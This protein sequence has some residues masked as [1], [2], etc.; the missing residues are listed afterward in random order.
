MVKIDG[1]QKPTAMTA[2]AIA[3]LEM[4]CN[5]CADETFALVPD[6]QNRPRSDLIPSGKTTTLIY[7]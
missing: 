3:E 4:L 5:H 6:R 1:T 7:S 2:S